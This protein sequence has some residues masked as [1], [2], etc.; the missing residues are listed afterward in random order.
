M[1]EISTFITGLEI[2]RLLQIQRFAS[3]KELLRMTQLTADANK[4]FPA[5]YPSVDPKSI[6]HQAKQ[7][8][9]DQ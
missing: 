4:V 3:P 7:I 2:A 8:I 6:I 1:R 9:F 5:D